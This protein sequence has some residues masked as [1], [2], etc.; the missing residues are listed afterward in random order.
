VVF[1]RRE[2]VPGK[3]NHALFEHVLDTNLRQLDN[4]S[5]RPHLAFT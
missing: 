5:Q 1:A 4:R 2:Q 3:G